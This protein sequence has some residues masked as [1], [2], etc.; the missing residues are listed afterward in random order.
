MGED[1]LLNFMNNQVQ[2]LKL[3][4]KKAS[5]KWNGRKNALIEIIYALHISNSIK[6]KSI[7]EIVRV[8]EGIFGIDLG[9]VHNA[10]D[11]MKYREKGVSLFLDKL[12][13]DL[14]MHTEEK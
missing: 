7:M 11:K 3:R 1:L 4:S 12:K 14:K 8:F 5:L 9:D 2:T 6:A 10:F 13:R